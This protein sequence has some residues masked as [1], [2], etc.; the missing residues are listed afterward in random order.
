MTLVHRHKL[1][2]LQCLDMFHHSDNLCA[3]SSFDDHI[4]VQSSLAHTHSMSHRFPNRRHTDRLHKGPLGIILVFS[5]ISNQCSQAY[6]NKRPWVDHYRYS[7]IYRC[8]RCNKNWLYT[9]RLQ[10]GY[11]HDYYTVCIVHSYGRSNMAR[12][13]KHMVVPHSGWESGHT[14]HRFCKDLVYR[15]PNSDFGWGHYSFGQCSLCRKI[16]VLRKANNKHSIT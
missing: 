7:R 1:L 6:T 15:R 8:H 11:L 4:L 16:I 12:K 14:F 9:N 3:G 13:H 5:H 10:A 2:Y